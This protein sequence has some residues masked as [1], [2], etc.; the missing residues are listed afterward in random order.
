MKPS[1]SGN[2]GMEL[3]R[4]ENV[5][6]IPGGVDQ[7]V[8]RFPNSSTH[9]HSLTS[10]LPFS[11]RTPWHFGHLARFTNASG[12]AGATSGMSSLMIESRPKMPLQMRSPSPDA[13][14][15]GPAP[16]LA[17]QSIVAGG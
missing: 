12:W 8:G 6:A 13:H 15:R 5:A 14:T 10:F 16:W 1:L 17:G 7:P 2:F 3:A 11:S 9:P 4:S